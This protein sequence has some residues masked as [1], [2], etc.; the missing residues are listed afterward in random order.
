M[1]ERQPAGRHGSALDSSRQLEC[2]TDAVYFEARGE[3]PR[4]QAA[5]AQVV[6]NRVKNPSFPKTVCGVVFQR[7]ASH[8]CQFSFVCDGSMRHGLETEAW[9]RARQIAERALSGRRLADIG[10][11]TH[12]HTT[13][14]QPDWGP[15]ML[16]VA[17]VGL[18]VFYRFNPHAR[19]DQPEDRPVLASLPVGPA[20]NL[21]LATA[22]FEKATDVTVAASGL[23]AAPASAAAKPAPAPKAPVATLAETPSAG[24][25]PAEAASPA[26]SAAS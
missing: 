16:R 11:A 20:S 19:I 1:D 26:D 14:V 4:G 7:V 17:Q 6:M 22:V 10:N 12:F 23:G 18:H 3:T 25:K 13:D 9:D 21:R 8:G 15:Q 2:L 24:P 5:V